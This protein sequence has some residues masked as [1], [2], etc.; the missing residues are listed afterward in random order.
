MIR[1]IKLDLRPDCPQIYG[2]WSEKCR[3]SDHQS[4]SLALRQQGEG[5]QKAS[6]TKH[7][8]VCCLQIQDIHMQIAVYRD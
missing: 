3:L 7:H 5:N 2:D 1:K 8:D 6:S 4:D